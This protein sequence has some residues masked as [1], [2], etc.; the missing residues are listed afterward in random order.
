MMIRVDVV[1]DD[2]KHSVAH[3]AEISFSAKARDAAKVELSNLGQTGI[4]YTFA[5]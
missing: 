2:Q 4:T 3:G 5:P 1:D